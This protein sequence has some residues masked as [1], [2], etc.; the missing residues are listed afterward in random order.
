VAKR[1]AFE[2]NTHNL[3]DNH[4][5]GSRDYHCAIDAVLCVTHNAEEVIKAGRAG[6]LVLFDIQG[7]FDNIVGGRAVR[8]LEI[9]GF[10]RELCAWTASFLTPRHTRLCF[11]GTTSAPFD[12]PT[13]VP[14]GSPLSPI[15]SA[16]YTS[17][18]L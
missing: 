8:M 3:V 18:M 15:L 17:M 7:F 4:Q 9:M 5:F 11:N 12:V 2:S 6:T 1:I 16:T 10:S 14:Q 13:G